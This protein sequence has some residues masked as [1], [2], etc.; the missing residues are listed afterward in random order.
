MILGFVE[1]KSIE[2]I[3]H[4][5]PTDAVYCLCEAS[6]PRAMKVHIL[7]DSFRRKNLTYF[8]Y[9]NVAEAFQETIVKASADD[10]IYVGGSTFVVADFLAWKKK[11]NSF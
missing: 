9:K 1:D 8:V 4:R 11:K 5:L 7:A 2:P 10:L 6:I 3:I